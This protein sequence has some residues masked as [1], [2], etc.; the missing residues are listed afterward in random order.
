MAEIVH[1]CDPQSRAMRSQRVLEVFE[2]PHRTELM[3]LRQGDAK[4]P[5]YEKI[6]PLR[7]VPALQHGDVT[8]IESGAICLYLADLFPEKM[9]TPRPGTPERARLYEWMFFLQT[10]LEPV[11]MGTFENPDKKPEAAAKVRELLEAMVGKF[12]GPY[13]LG[14]EFTVADVILHTELDWY[15]MMGFF[16]QGLEPYETFMNTMEKHVKSMTQKA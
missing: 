5:G 3:Q 6:H 11:V 13:V 14:E 1:Y 4:K 12:K 8:I 16:P 10:T 9:K 15:R 2:I 7:R